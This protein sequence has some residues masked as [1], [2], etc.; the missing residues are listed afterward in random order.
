MIKS[1]NLDLSL[2]VLLHSTVIGSNFSRTS[3]FFFTV[4]FKILF[5]DLSFG[6][7]FAVLAFLEVLDFFAARFQRLTSISSS[8]SSSDSK[9]AT[10]FGFR[11]CPAVGAGGE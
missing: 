6:F 4:F 3:S 11:F 1:L 5:G 2:M 9:V 10:F 8:E 7:V